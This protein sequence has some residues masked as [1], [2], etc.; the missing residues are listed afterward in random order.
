MEKRKKEQALRLLLAEII[1]RFLENLF[2]M[3]IEALNG[4]SYAC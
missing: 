2:K 3:I 1:H 4:L